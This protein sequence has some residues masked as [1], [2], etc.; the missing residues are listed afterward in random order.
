MAE[1]TWDP[2]EG[3]ELPT[4]QV[5]ERLRTRA[6]RTPALEGITLLGG[7]PFEQAGPVGEVAQAA[8]AL[9]L[10]VIAFTGFTLEE[11]QARADPQVSSLLGLVDL[12]IDGSYQAARRDFSR[13][14][15]G[16]ANQRFLFLTDRY[17]P[18][19]LARERNHVELRVRPDGSVAVNGMMDFL[20][21]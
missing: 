11:L 6:A 19:D 2:A 8:R 12:L 10:S 5:C 9:G 13:P 21:V 17:G 16:S 3:E 20:A 14:W 1:D 18:E 7:E 15:A 4:E